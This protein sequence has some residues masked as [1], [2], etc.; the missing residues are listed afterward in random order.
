MKT[1]CQ[2]LMMIVCLSS[3]AVL[4][5]GGPVYSLDQM[6][7]HPY[8]FVPAYGHASQNPG[9][10]KWFRP[11]YGYLIPGFGSTRGLSVGGSGRYNQHDGFGLRRPNDRSVA[12]TP[13]Y[14]PGQSIYAGVR[15]D[16][17]FAW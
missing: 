11:G 10:P 3:S 1:T 8:R 17:E 5:D 15:S 6:M 14:F 12:M 13:W 4:A 9:S 7:D 2:F 16:A